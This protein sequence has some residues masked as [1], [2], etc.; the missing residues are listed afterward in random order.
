MK[1]N[2]NEGLRHL[3][4]GN[5]LLGLPGNILIWEIS[6]QKEP[7]LLLRHLAAMFSEIYTNG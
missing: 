1:M 2:N 4:I 3:Y 5:Y 6:Y 7:P